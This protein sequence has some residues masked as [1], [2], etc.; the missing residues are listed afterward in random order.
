ME[1]KNFN[2]EYPKPAEE[3]KNIIELE[4][5][6]ED[7]EENA[8]ENS[9]DAKIENQT[10]EKELLPEKSREEKKE[11]LE[12]RYKEIHD[13]WCE[14]ENNQKDLGVI[15]KIKEEGI[16]TMI[17][18]YGLDVVFD[19]ILGVE[20]G[21][22]I[23][24]VLKKIEPNDKKRKNLYAQMLVEVNSQEEN[25]ET[26]N[27]KE[28]SSSLAKKL[29]IWKSLDSF[30]VMNRSEKIKNLDSGLQDFHIFLMVQEEKG[31]NLKEELSRAGNSINEIIRARAEDLK[32]KKEELV[33]Q[34]EEISNEL[35]SE[36]KEIEEEFTLTLKK[37]CDQAWSDFDD[38]EIKEEE[39]RKAYLEIKDKTD[40]MAEKTKE[41][42]YEATQQLEAMKNEIPALLL[43]K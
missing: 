25:K 30:F 15:E 9:N 32:N 24:D 38:L 12:S 16:E 2:P 29:E 37:Y 27:N 21:E 43:S 5:E 1:N 41:E 7:I 4:P 13:K 20:K 3:E 14:M 17:K 35:S 10:E 19:A 18:E 36:I 31:N 39:K 34:L 26:E 23:V 11:K 28:K 40:L 22:T 6:N 8:Q 42:T 33:P